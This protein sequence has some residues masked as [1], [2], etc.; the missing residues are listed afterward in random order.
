MHKIII[1]VI[2]KL[3]VLISVS[4]LFAVTSKQLTSSCLFTLSEK[5]KSFL[6]G[7]T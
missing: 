1:V 5:V 3:E 7:K 2:N 6:H 4:S